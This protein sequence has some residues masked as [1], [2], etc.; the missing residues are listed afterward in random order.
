MTKQYFDQDELMIMA[1]YAAKTKQEAILAIKDAL[2]ELERS[3]EDP[4]DEDM[5]EVLSSLI[6]K[7]QVL[8]DQYYYG[9]DLQEYLYDIEE[10]MDDA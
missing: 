3:G 2:E 1:I 9:L 4:S 10:G 6:E 5:T 8:Q 7:L